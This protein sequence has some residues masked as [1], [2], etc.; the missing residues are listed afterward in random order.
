MIPWNDAKKTEYWR[1][2]RVQDSIKSAKVHAST[3]YCPY[4]KFHV[5]AVVLTAEGQIF[6]GCNIEN[7]SYGLTICAERV[8][9]FRSWGRHNSV[10]NDLFVYCADL[11]L[12]SP[13]T[14]TMPCGA[15]RQV[16]SEFMGSN[17]RVWVINFGLFTLSELLPHAF[18][19][20]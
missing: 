18:K 15:C 13:I 9:L 20:S 2:D 16:M 10:I 17:S 1:D 5:G 6:G 19:L 7:A 14:F 11:P 3:A 8:A 12:Q 4:S